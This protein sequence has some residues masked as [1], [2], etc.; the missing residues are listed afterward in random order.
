MLNE[1]CKFPYKLSHGFISS[2]IFS[3]FANFI[4]EWSQ[5]DFYF[6]NFGVIL[7]YLESSIRLSSTWSWHVYTIVRDTRSNCG[8]PL[9]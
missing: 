5:C 8:G 1:R 6:T 7:E 2:M 3:G 9:T 4:D